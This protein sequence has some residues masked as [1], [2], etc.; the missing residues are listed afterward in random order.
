MVAINLNVTDKI[1]NLNFFVDL[2]KNRT[3]T[4]ERER[5]RELIEKNGITN[6]L[7]KERSKP[8]SYKKENQNT[9]IDANEENEEG[10]KPRNSNEKKKRNQQQQQQQKRNILVAVDSMLTS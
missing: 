9:I 4:F 1:K 7:L 3:S 5:E 10:T 8:I 2:L 6:F